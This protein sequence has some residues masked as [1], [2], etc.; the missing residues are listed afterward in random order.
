MKKSKQN[1]T[2]ST[3]KAK[4][5]ITKIEK[6]IAKSKAILSA[7]G[8]G[9]S[10]QDKNYVIVY[11]NT[12]HKKSFG[13]HIGE[14]CYKAY[15]LRE[16]ICEK[17]PISAT[18]KDGRIHKLQRELQTEK[19]I[20][21]IEIA[22]SPLKNSK[23]NIIAG[24]ELVRDITDRKQAE[25]ALKDR[26]ALLQLQFNRMPIGCITWDVNFLVISWNPAAEKIF[27]FTLEDAK[28]KH[29]YELIVPQD[30]QPHVDTIW[31]RLLEGDITAHSE[32]EN[33]TKNGNFITCYWVNTPLKKP[34]GT[35]I[36]VISM[37][38]DIT[39]RKKAEESLKKSEE[40]LIKR[41]KELE[42]FYDMAIGRELRMI[43]LKKEIQ[44][45]KE[46]LEKYK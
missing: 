38:Q 17:C 32:N 7:M 44:I 23:G 39:D 42:D 41:V 29:P 45:L 18:F 15:R 31:Q 21:Y 26:E 36:G 12:I 2:K 33:I 6:E 19:E 40:E 20:R 16:N 1:Q 11:Q 28:G 46:E 35:I 13:N 25:E 8:D 22:T 5:I 37:V 3:G 10:I 30:A 4:E 43:Q 9:I 14:Y 24:I 27:G 34:D